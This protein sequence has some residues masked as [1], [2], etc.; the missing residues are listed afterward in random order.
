V[1]ITETEMLE[2]YYEALDKALT[3]E[4]YD[5]FFQLAKKELEHTLDL[6]INGL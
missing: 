1:E 6:Y 3:K 2:K 4:I 5:D